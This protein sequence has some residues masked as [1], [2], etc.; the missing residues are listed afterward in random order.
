[1]NTEILVTEIVKAIKDGKKV[2]TF[3]V[4]G[5]A[6]NAMHF[7]AE[8]AGK[9]E[10]YEKPLPCI[11]LVSNPCIVTA[12]A[13]DFGFE[14]VFERQIR[15]IAKPGDVLIGFS[16]STNGQYLLKAFDEGVCIPCECFLIC[17]RE[18][19]N[20]ATDVFVMEFDSLDTPTVQE[21]QL[22]VIHQICGKVKMSLS[23]K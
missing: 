18:T 10:Q 7:A 13:Q 15:G 16:V 9:F 4:G 11:D 14:H 6:G 20:L 19:R 17:G 22:K 12:I 23:G 2:I 21:E 3:G 1:M 5:N 8:L